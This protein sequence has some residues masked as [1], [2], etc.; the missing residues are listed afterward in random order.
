MSPEESKR[1]M[2]WRRRNSAKGARQHV[3]QVKLSDEEFALLTAHA[4]V[5]RCSR[6]M[7]LMSSWKSGGSDT[8][9]RVQMLQDDLLA[10]RRLLARVS[11]NLN[12]AVKLV[13]TRRL[14]GVAD[15]YEL[16]EAL[17]D[18]MGD[19]PVVLKDIERVTG[20][21]EHEVGR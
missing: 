11:A 20:W 2:P 13:H 3:V 4:E 10:A 6:P 15:G 21:V 5:R 7:V 12:Q 16:D 18:L 17:N 19:L 9:A 8:A 1:Q 14:E